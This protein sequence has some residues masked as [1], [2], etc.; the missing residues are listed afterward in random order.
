LRWPFIPGQD[1]P[2]LALVRRAA[3]RFVSAVPA[4]VAVPNP[5]GPIL[6]VVGAADSRILILRIVRKTTAMTV[7]A[8]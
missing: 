7:R 3:G 2:S 6:L 1:I 8:A 4:G 5:V